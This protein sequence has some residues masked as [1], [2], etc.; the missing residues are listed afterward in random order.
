VSLSVEFRSISC[1]ANW[2]TT[3]STK[4]KW[5]VS[6]KGFGNIIKVWVPF[7]KTHRTSTSGL[8]CRSTFWEEKFSRHMAASSVD[9]TAARYV[10]RVFDCVVTGRRREEMY[11]ADST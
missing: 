7:H 1:N 11:S 3:F 10:A 8:L 2:P 9:R 4:S 5:R 6:W